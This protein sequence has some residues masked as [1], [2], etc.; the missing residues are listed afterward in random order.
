MYIYICVCGIEDGD[1]TKTKEIKREKWKVGERERE[2]S[3]KCNRADEEGFEFG[4]GLDDACWEW[5]S[6]KQSQELQ[7]RNYACGKDPALRKILAL[8][9]R[10]ARA[11]RHRNQKRNRKDLRMASPAAFF[12][13]APHV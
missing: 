6:L 13:D 2:S 4:L 7:L 8:M 9:A 1:E 12:L 3:K 5:F 10:Q 11:F